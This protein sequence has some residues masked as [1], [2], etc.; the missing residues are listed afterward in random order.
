MDEKIKV[1]VI[2]PRGFP[3]VQGGIERFSESFYPLFV[4]LGYNVNVFVMK[5]Y[6]SH[7]QWKGV[8]FIH[9]PTVSSK[10][11]EKFF[12]NFYSAIY[13]IIKRPDVIH[14]HSIAS[15]FFIFLLKASG[16][17]VISRYNSRDYLHNKWSRLGKFILKFSEKQFLKSDYI[18]TNNKSYL[19]FLKSLGRDKN[20]TFLPNGVEWPDITNYK[21]FQKSIYANILESNKYILYVGRITAEKN[22]KTLLDAY[23]KLN[24]KSLKLVIAGEAAHQ[25]EYFKKLQL[26]Y[27]T[28]E[29]VFLGKVERE[30]LNYLYAHS[31]L[32]VLP[33]LQEGMP[34]VL[35]EAMSFKCSI[36]LSDIPAHQQFVFNE[37]T[38][39]KTTDVDDLM[40][41]MQFKIADNY[42]EED[43]SGK[44][45]DY[46]WDTIVAKMQKIHAEVLNN[47]INDT[48]KN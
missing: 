42:T 4:S 27:S 38:Y 43:Y 7:K 30:Q 25:D 48:R 20:L 47:T 26:N 9:V 2:G 1:F 21:L 45:L 33:S 13:C 23:I 46:S 19:D 15:G 11:L 29:I 31:R 28:P 22:I 39:F 3:G 24:D 34:N 18:V 44:L 12:Y 37:N 17:K 14:I 41:K 10:T 6:C 5:K 16:L 8:N 36:L 35:L 40:R 32:F